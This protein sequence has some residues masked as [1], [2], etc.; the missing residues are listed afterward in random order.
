MGHVHE[1]AGHDVEDKIT[2][3]LGAFDAQE[4]KHGVK[5]NNENAGLK[6]IER[7]R[8]DRV[9]MPAAHAAHG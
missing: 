8:D 6:D 3:D 5:G 4:R 2:T 1:N 9:R 7:Q